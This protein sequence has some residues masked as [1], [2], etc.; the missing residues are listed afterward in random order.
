MKSKLNWGYL[1]DNEY[2]WN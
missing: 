1:C 2:S